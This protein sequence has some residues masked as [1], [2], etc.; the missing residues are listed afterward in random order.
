MFNL[1][2]YLLATKLSDI[3]RM[4]QWQGARLRI[5]RLWVRS[6]LWSIFFF[7]PPS[8][9]FL[10]HNSF[11][12]PIAGLMGRSHHV[13]VSSLA[14][15]HRHTLAQGAARPAMGC[16]G[17]STIDGNSYFVRETRVWLSLQLTE[18]Y[19]TLS[20]CILFVGLIP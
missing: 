12:W 15:L 8:V 1:Y 17:P 2:K 5:W 20:V 10:I 9:I 6:P 14:L 13:Q 18:R 4:A 3:G 16:Q 7:F 11:R 19:T